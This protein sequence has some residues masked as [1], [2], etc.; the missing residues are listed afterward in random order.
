MV[1]P[2]LTAIMSLASAVSALYLGLLVQRRTS[3]GNGAAATAGRRAP[4]A[5][6]PKRMIA[7]RYPTTAPARVACGSCGLRV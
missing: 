6:P 5:R 3:A 7:L 4:T 1:H 2:A